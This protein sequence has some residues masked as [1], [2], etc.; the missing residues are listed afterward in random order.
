MLLLLNALCSVVCGDEEMDRK[1]GVVA[2]TSTV[3]EPH[4]G[5]TGT[6]R[7]RGRGREGSRTFQPG[8]VVVN[9]QKGNELV[10]SDSSSW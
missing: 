2:V 9:G 4:W 1:W 8:A 3:E 5:P 10:T 7:G 6:G